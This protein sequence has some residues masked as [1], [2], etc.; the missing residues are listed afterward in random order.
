MWLCIVMA[1][2]CKKIYAFM[3]QHETDVRELMLKFPG[4]LAP[5]WF[6]FERHYK[7][8][9][10]TFLSTDAN[11]YAHHFEQEHVLV[12]PPLSRVLKGNIELQYKSAG[13]GASERTRAECEMFGYKNSLIF[14][15]YE[16]KYFD[17]FYFAYQG[18]S[19]ELMT[20]LQNGQAVMM[21]I[22]YDFLQKFENLLGDRDNATVISEKMRCHRRF[23]ERCGNTM[24]FWV[25]KRQE[26]IKITARQYEV[27]F[28]RWKKKPYKS[29]ARMLD[30]RPGTPEK[31]MQ[32][33]RERLGAE[34]VADIFDIIFG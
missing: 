1:S 12:S 29:I 3:K 24:S 4:E 23:Y 20:A 25:E 21:G 27:A 33:L 30:V 14:I 22:L 9:L 28:L 32:A 26:H 17:V 18:V 19:D 10:C 2:I 15:R 8:G 7:S 16:N 34:A 5:C 31:H 13:R 6:G 11:V